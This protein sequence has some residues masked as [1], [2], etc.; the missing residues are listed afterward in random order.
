MPSSATQLCSLACK[1]QKDSDN[2]TACNLGH[3]SVCAYLLPSK[4][5]STRENVTPFSAPLDKQTDKEQADVMM[6]N[7]KVF[8]GIAIS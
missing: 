6:Q 2:V 1:L 5:M 8:G 4:A 3:P 7:L